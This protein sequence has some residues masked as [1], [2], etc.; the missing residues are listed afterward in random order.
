MKRLR[1]EKTSQS[2]CEGGAGRR[3]RRQQP[4]G[5]AAGAGPGP[6]FAY[7]YSPDT[8]FLI[9]QSVLTDAPSPLRS[10]RFFTAVLHLA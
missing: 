3:A 8:P 2:A 5:T 6:I 1:N 4:P 10:L 7:K 9:N